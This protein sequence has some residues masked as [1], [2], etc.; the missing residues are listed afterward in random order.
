MSVKDD[1]LKEMPR[2]VIISEN[3]KVHICANCVLAEEAAEN[4]GFKGEVE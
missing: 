4:T 3:K 1:C 2:C